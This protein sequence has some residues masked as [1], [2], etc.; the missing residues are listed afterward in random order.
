MTSH[1]ARTVRAP[2]GR[3]RS[4]RGWTQEA[5]LRML[6]NN[7]D[8]EVAEKPEDLVVYGGRERPPATG[9]P[10]MPSWRTL[11]ELERRRDPPDPVGQARGGLPDFSPRSAGPHRQ[12]EPGG[13]MG[14]LGALPRAGAEGS[15]DVRPDDRRLMDLYRHAGDPP[16]HLRDLRRHGEEALRGLS[17]GTVDPDRRSRGDGRSPASRGHLQRRVRFSS[18]KW[19]PREFSGVWT[20]GTATGRPST[21]TRRC[22]GS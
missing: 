3:E 6:M 2:R 19:I 12:R 7:L 22:G 4:C 18:W 16:G 8:P 14:H 20:P 1:R 5:A 11:K 13:S 9:R 10:S 21:W 17:E 15:D